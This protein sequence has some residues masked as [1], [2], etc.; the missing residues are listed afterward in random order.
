MSE[1]GVGVSHLN[2]NCRLYTSG[3]SRSRGGGRARAPRYSAS[4]LMYRLPSLC[5]ES[6]S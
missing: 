4:S 3:R 1:H 5:V 2:K 6:Y